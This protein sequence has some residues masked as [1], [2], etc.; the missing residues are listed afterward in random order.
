MIWITPKLTKLTGYLAPTGFVAE[1]KRELGSCVR[2]VHGDLAG[3]WEH[4][5][6]RTTLEACDETVRVSF[7]RFNVAAAAA[8]LIHGL[9]WSKREALA[10]QPSGRRSAVRL[11]SLCSSYD[12]RQEIDWLLYVLVRTCKGLR[13]FKDKARTS[14]SSST[15]LHIDW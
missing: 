9:T 6:P 8:I 11:Q 13:A 4:G 2:D 10:L 7:N 14:G 1:L 15:Q 3:R 5:L 12:N